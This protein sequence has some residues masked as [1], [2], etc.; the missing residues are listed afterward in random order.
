MFND[1]SERRGN[2]Y[3]FLLLDAPNVHRADGARVVQSRGELI[4]A[5][6]FNAVLDEPEVLCEGLEGARLVPQL[7]LMNL[8]DL[9]VAGL[10]VFD[11]H[12][13]AGEC[14]A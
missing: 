12:L 6:H 10:G 8:V 14:R 4:P 5:A 7:D 3:C 1:S 11:K 9:S 13:E 2:C